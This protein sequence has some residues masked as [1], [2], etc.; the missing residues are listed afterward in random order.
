MTYYNARQDEEAATLDGMNEMELKVPT[1]TLEEIAAHTTH[2]TG[3]WVTYGSAVYDITEFV[4]NHPGGS[5]IM[6]AAGKSVEPF[7]DI[8]TIHQTPEVRELLE[9]MCIGR[10]DKDSLAEMKRRN[11]EAR[12]NDPY[13]KDPK[14]HPGYIINSEKPFDA[15]TPPQILTDHF[16]TP[17]ELF[18]V[19]NHLPVPQITE[20][21]YQLEISIPGRE[22]SLA[23]SLDDL[24]TK[25][26]QHTITAT[27]QCAGNRRDGM[28]KYQKIYGAP[29]G[30]TAISNATWRGVKLCDVLKY[31][32]LEDSAEGIN[33]V[34]FQGWDKDLSGEPYGASI[35]AGKALDPRGDVLLAFEMNGKVLDKDHGY[36]VRVVAAGYVGA[37]N[38]KWLRKI[39]VC[40]EESSLFWQKKDYKSSPPS[41]KYD[42]YNFEDAPA[43]YESPVQS[44]I[45]FPENGSSIPADDGTITVK[46]YAHSGG[47]KGI[48]RVDV[49]ADGG[50]TWTTASLQQENQERD[51]AWSWTLWEADVDIPEGIQK[52]KMEIMCKAVDTSHNVQP[53]SV[54]GIWNLRGFLNNSW[55]RVNIELKGDDLDGEEKEK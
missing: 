35:P 29:S 52:G 50:K 33:H 3:I 13:K 31:A 9:E 26:P 38:V 48:L 4:E 45:C 6:L 36:P 37:R 23:L 20:K 40:T 28:H 24:R 1:Y 21:E 14:R 46:G 55:H 19:R 43:I 7:W 42:E 47:G 18:M 34:E 30:F 44:A 39:D 41:V 17:N 11:Q 12:K 10:I 2:E 32:G 51:R 8:Y 22:G 15:E 16:Y 25:F 53:E 27:I 5:K 49:S 54:S